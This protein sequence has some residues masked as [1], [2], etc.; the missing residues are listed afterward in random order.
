M[1]EVDL[2]CLLPHTTSGRQRGRTDLGARHLNIEELHRADADFIRIWSGF[3][4][5]SVSPLVSV[6]NNVAA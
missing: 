4:I 5:G 6:T 3:A 1:G 2:L